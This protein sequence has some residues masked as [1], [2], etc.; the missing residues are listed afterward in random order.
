MPPADVVEVATRL[1]A[2][3]WSWQMVD[4]PKIS[5]A[6]GW[7]TISSRP[8]RLI[9][10]TG[11]GPD[12]GNIQAKNG[13]VVRIEVQ[14]T[15]FADAATQHRVAEAFEAVAEAMSEKFGVPTAAQSGPPAQLRWAGPETTLLLNR[16]TASVWVALVTNARL[17]ADDRNIELEEQGL[18]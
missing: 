12:S 16:L 3:D 17:A 6:F 14:V 18:L 5:T 13:Q 10:D 15:D 1:R 9:L 11:L 7:D 4:A 8:R 2:L